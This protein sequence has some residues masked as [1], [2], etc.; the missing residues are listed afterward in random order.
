MCC[1]FFS[2]LLFFVAALAAVNGQ[3]V[4]YAFS[5]VNERLE[6]WLG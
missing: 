6:A 3:N 4:R 2:M 1:A 5:N